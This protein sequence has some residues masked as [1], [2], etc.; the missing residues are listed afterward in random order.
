M[1]QSG[2]GVHAS[3]LPLPVGLVLRH[4]QAVYEQPFRPVYHGLVAPA[5][6]GGGEALYVFES[7][8]A[9]LSYI[10]LHMDDWQTQNYVA[11]CGAAFAPVANSFFP[12]V[13]ISWT[14]W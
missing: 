14:F 7:P 1:A 6:A 8:I 12:I 11:C 9:L 5:A 3:L 2:S 4:T 13:T 10:T